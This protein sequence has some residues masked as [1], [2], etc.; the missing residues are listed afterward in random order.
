MIV[1]ARQD[2]KVYFEAVGFICRGATI[3]MTP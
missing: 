1:V 3:R 2:C